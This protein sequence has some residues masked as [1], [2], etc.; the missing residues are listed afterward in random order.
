MCTFQNYFYI[1]AAWCFSF[2]TSLSWEDSNESPNV[3]PSQACLYSPQILNILCMEG[4][5]G[6]SGICSRRG[7]GGDDLL[8]H[9]FLRGW[10]DHSNVLVWCP[11]TIDETGPWQ[12]QWLI[13]VRG[14]AE[15]QTQC[16]GSPSS[17][18]CTQWRL[19]YTQPSLSVMSLESI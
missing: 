5:R 6:K 8:N 12:V 1:Q 13:Q 18:C 19:Y 9:K 2:H 15:T 7:E 4:I 16:P 10:R 11:L 17:T 14:R 3:L